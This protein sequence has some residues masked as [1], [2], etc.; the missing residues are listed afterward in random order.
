MAVLLA[1]FRKGWRGVFASLP[2]QSQ[3]KDE[4]PQDPP[5]RPP[6]P[7]QA[8]PQHRKRCKPYCGM[9]KRPQY[10]FQ[11]REFERA[12]NHRHG[13]CR[14]LVHRYRKESRIQPNLR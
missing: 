11:K 4:S 1:G 8:E 9:L 14:S 2:D 5:Y 7:V 3:E 12:V 13:L 6:G 10:C